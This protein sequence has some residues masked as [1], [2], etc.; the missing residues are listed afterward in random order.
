MRDETAPEAARLNIFALPALITVINV[1]VKFPF[2]FFSG[3]GL[4]DVHRVDRRGEGGGVQQLP[5]QPAAVQARTGVQRGGGVGGAL[6]LDGDAVLR[7][8]HSAP[9][10]RQQPTDVK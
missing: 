2:A 10:L 9:A 3:L 8:R 6:L 7:V 5:R 1:D 4:P